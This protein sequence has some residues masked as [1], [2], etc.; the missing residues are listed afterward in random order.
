MGEISCGEEVDKGWSAPDK[1]LAQ[2]PVGLSVLEFLCVRELH[3]TVSQ[4][5]IY[6]RR[7]VLATDLQVHISVGAHKEAL[8]LE[9]P[10][11]PHI[12]RLASQLLDERFRVDG[13][14]LETSKHGEGIELE[15]GGIRWTW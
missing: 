8:V 10:L 12:D 14:D 1:N 7:T 3:G 4:M 15:R 6:I 11:E 9:T 13:V 5:K 2:S